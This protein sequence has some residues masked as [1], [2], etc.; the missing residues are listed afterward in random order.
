ML[1]FWGTTPRALVPQEGAQSPSSEFPQGH[2][3]T[4][5]LNYLN[6]NEPIIAF[7][8][9]LQAVQLF[10][11][12]LLLVSSRCTNTTDS[13]RSP[14]PWRGTLTQQPRIYRQISTC[15]GMSIICSSRCKKAQLIIQMKRSKNRDKRP[16][17]AQASNECISPAHW[18]VCRYGARSLCVCAYVRDWMCM[19]LSS[20]NVYLRACQS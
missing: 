11:P 6:I 8:T 20:F 7:L 13:L 17:A 5:C 15:S 9:D 10:Y 18:C 19:L 1:I 2:N 3:L 14:K 12:H 16:T 4:H